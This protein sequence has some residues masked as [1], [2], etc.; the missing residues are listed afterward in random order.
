MRVQIAG[1][2]TDWSKPI[3]RQGHVGGICDLGDVLAPEV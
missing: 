3:S 2:V 1:R